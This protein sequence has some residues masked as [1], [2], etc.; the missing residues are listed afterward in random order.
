MR[1]VGRLLRALA[2]STALFGVASA[3]PQAESS[4]RRRSGWFASVPAL[5][6]IVLMLVCATAASAA[7]LSPAEKADRFF[8]KYSTGR[9]AQAGRPGVVPRYPGKLVDSQ[10]V[11]AAFEDNRTSEILVMTR[12]HEV[13]QRA[14]EA[15]AIRRLRGELTSEYVLL[16]AIER[17]DVDFW[18]LPQRGNVTLPTPRGAR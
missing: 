9:K 12:T 18:V 3:P 14:K 13:R 4:A 17:G 16:R 5:A 11:Q 6:L 15:Q 1:S 7:P 2:A 8:E 10:E